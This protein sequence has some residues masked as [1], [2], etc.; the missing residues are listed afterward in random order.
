METRRTVRNC[1]NVWSYN[2]PKDWEKLKATREASVRRCGFC[3]HD[4]HLCTT[5]AETIAL[6]EK[7]EFIARETPVPYPEGGDCATLE[8]AKLSEGAAHEARID[9]A[10]VDLKS[11]HRTC[12]KCSWPVA[13]RKVRCAV[14]KFEIGR[15]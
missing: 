2:C 10:L 3:K 15:A 11:P 5:D 6:A 12:P 8:H 13:N 7:G 4:V 14:C 1:D 9:I